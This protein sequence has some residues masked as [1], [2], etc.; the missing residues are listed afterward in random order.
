MRF[1]LPLA[2]HR[3]Q[4]TRKSSSSDSY[5]PLAARMS[6]SV[7]KAGQADSSD[8]D[9]PLSVR[10][11][12]ANKKQKELRTLHHTNPHP[13][14]PLAARQ[15][16]K[17]RKTRSKITPAAS[18]SEIP[19]EPQTPDIGLAARLL[20]KSNPSEATT[21]PGV[22]KRGRPQKATRGRTALYSTQERNQR[23]L[24]SQRRYNDKNKAARLAGILQCQ[25]ENPAMLRAAQQRYAEKHPEVHREAQQRYAE[26]HPEVHREAQ[27]RYAEQHP[28]VH[29]EA[30]QQ[31]RATHPDREKTRHLSNDMQALVREHGPMAF[32]R[33]D[34]LDNIKPY[35]LKKPN[36]FADDIFKCT[37]CG[38]HLFEEEPKTALWCCGKGAYN[39]LNLPPLQADFYTNPDFRQRARAYNDL[40][41]LCALNVSGGIRHPRDGLAFFKIEG[42][43]YHKIYSL[44]HRGQHTNY[45]NVSRYVNNCRL[46]L[47]D[48][49]ERR[50]LAKGRNLKPVI[51]DQA[52][53]FLLA[54][55]PFLVQF[56]L[57]SDAPAEDARLDFQV[58]TRAT[59]GPVLGDNKP[60][61]EV[62]AVIRNGETL[63]GAPRSL[64]VWERADRYPTTINSFDPLMEP[65]QYPLL[66]P[67]GTPGWHFTRVDKKNKKLSQLN[68]ARCLLLSEP[69]FTELGR[70]SQAWQV[71]M[72]ARIE[73]ERLQYIARCQQKTIRMP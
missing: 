73:E 61:L 49:A 13:D 67:N 26:Q 48:G 28:E 1:R 60:G 32:W 33:G 31:Y 58:T 5:T 45:I 59:H 55:N 70:L 46:Y 18:D 65:F 34:L 56:R 12:P 22:P 42:R 50:E 64:T 63:A 14:T 6:H 35:G 8:S 53:S 29:R 15:P 7:Q 25:Q 54:N 19:K 30:Q 40:L 44:N 36:L 37:Y 27:L 39:V 4:E 9:T 68:Y 17:R 71:E 62:H 41:A 47:D 16:A 2:Q 11:L 57:L 38:A 21:S 43:M 23:R 72:Q 3:L 69:R 20:G 51:I 66:Y 24:D 10:R 52:K